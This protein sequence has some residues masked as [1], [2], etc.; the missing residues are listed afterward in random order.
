MRITQTVDRTRPSSR[1]APRQIARYPGPLFHTRTA[2]LAR[3]RRGRAGRR[4][5]PV[6]ALT[7]DRDIGQTYV[8]TRPALV[9]HAHMATI[10]SVATGLQVEYERADAERFVDLP[11]NAGQPEWLANDMPELSMHMDHDATESLETLVGRLPIA[12]ER[13]A[14]E[15]VDAFGLAHRA[16]AR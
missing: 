8:V 12:F 11:L 10:G 7:E 1:V 9:L 13:F 15:H 2:R 5:L 16:S 4:A 14:R 6:G 3:Q